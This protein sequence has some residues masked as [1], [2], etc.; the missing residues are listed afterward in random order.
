MKK[1]G[2][3]LVLAIVLLALCSSCSSKG[4]VSDA[5]AGVVSAGERSIELRSAV[6]ILNDYGNTPDVDVIFFSEELSEEEEAAFAESGGWAK[7]I[8]GKFAIFKIGFMFEEEATVCDLQNLRCY[9]VIFYD[10]EAFSVPVTVGYAQ[11]VF[12][13]LVRAAW[14]EGKDGVM[15]L[16][17]DLTKGRAIRA[18]V[19]HEQLYA[20]DLAPGVDSL[21]LKW[22]ISV[23]CP[24]RMGV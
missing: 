12:G 21:P 2:H 14:D 6:A 16:A 24:L 4:S 10:S 20:M 17:G 3:V 11:C 18:R 15:Q 22:D 23:D 1:F 19:T 13:G 8:N 7:E 5:S 9:N